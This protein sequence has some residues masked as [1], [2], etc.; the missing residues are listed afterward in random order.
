MKKLLIVPFLALTALPLH[1]AEEARG[2]EPVCRQ[3]RQRDLDAR[4][5]R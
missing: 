1:A 3:S 4:D 5:F 2:A